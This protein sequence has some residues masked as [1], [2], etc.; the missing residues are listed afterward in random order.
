[1]AGKISE[2]FIGSH[3]VSQNCE[4]TSIAIYVRQNVAEKQELSD[5]VS[6][7]GIGD[8]ISLI[9]EIAALVGDFQVREFENGR[10][11]GLLVETRAL[12]FELNVHR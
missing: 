8:Y 7:T 3:H 6:L 1:V 2:F 9:A 12:V 4:K 10:V 11:L 5:L